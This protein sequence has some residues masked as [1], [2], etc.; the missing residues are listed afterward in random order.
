MMGTYAKH[1]ETKGNKNLTAVVLIETSHIAF[2]IC[3]VQE[4]AMLQFNLNTCGKL[5]KE[6]VIKA[7][8]ER[9]DVVFM[10]WLLYARA[11]GFVLEEK[12]SI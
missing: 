3:D 2:H 4:P 12:G 9:L 5:E 11:C 6:Q 10:D 1:V 8:Q 7:I